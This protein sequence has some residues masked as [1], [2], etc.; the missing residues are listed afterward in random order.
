MR[1]QEDMSFGSPFANIANFCSGGDWTAV[2]F[3]FFEHSFVYFLALYEFTYN[4]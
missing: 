3:F 2:I 1:L 4:K